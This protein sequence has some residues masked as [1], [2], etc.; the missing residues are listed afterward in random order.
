MTTEYRSLLEPI[1]FRSNGGKIVASG[2]AMRYGTKSNPIRG[3]FRETFKPGSLA[4]SLTAG[5]PEVRSHLEH[6]G[7]YLGSTGNGTL[8]LTDTRSELAYEID[9]PDTQP[10]RDAAYLLERRDLRGASIGFDARGK[11]RTDWSV[12]TDGVALRSVNEADLILVDLTVAPYYDDTTA[13]VALRSFADEHQLE[14]RSV[15][16]ATRAGQF[17]TLLGSEGDHEEQEADTSHL[18]TVV[19]R[20][21][22]LAM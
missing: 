9:I 7:G 16:D 3:Q 6:F 11:G 10:G 13:E 21:L 14:L 19:V 1:E 4:K 20:P 5:K 2:V 22:L 18:E 8:R 12:D 17:A 15:I